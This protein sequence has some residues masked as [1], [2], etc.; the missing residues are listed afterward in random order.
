MLSFYS[1][2]KI[3]YFQDKSNVDYHINLGAKI[4][5]LLTTACPRSL[6][7]ILYKLAIQQVPRSLYGKNA[8]ET[9]LCVI[10]L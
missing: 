10:L 9:P 6:L 3:I 5:N 8:L 4:S 1:Y 2:D 7:C